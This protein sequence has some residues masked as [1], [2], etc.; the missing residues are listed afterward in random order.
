MQDPNGF[1]SKMTPSQWF[2]VPKKNTAF[3]A[4]FLLNVAKLL[5][6]ESL[7]WWMFDM[8]VTKNA[9]SLAVYFLFSAENQKLFVIKFNNL[10]DNVQILNILQ[11]IKQRNFR[12]K[13]KTA[14]F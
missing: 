3:L 6:F 9:D 1:Q 8:T 7:K 2:C 10:T 13:K 11:Q 12:L 4:T 14:D 5:R